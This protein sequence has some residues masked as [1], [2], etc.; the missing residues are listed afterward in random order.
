MVAQRV[1]S[2]HEGQSEVKGCLQSCEEGVEFQH[3]GRPY[4][5]CI[6]FSALEN[7]GGV[8]ICTTVRTF[9]I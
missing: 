2:A 1:E 8:F 6:D 9:S 4:I 7:M 3:V 5:N